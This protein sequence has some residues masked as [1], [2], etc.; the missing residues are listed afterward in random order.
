MTELYCLLSAI[1]IIAFIFSMS[2]LK[3]SIGV[4]A[5]ISFILAFLIGRCIMGASL[6]VLF[7]GCLEGLWNTFIIMV[8]VF[9]ALLLYELLEKSK[10]LSTL[11][12]W[13]GSH[14]ED[15]VDQILMIGWVFTSFLQGVTG[16]GVPV[17]VAA[18]I[19]TGLG[20]EP[21]KAVIICILGHAWGGTFGTLGIAW[22][23]M[24]LQLP[25]G[26]DVYMGQTILYTCILLGIYNFICGLLICAL[27]KG[28][29]IKAR[30]LMA[31]ALISSVQSMGQLLFALF[32]NESLACFLASA[33]SM[34]VLYVWDRGL[35]RGRTPVSGKSGSGRNGRSDSNAGS[36]PVVDMG[37][38]FFI[39]SAIVFLL[40]M[41]TKLSAALEGCRVGMPV[42]DP[43]GGWTVYGAVSVFTHSGTILLT[44]VAVSFWFYR[45]KKYLCRED[46]GKML[47]NAGRKTVNAV[48]PVLFLVMMSR[49]MSGSGQIGFLASGIGELFGGWVGFASPFIGILGSFIS[50]SN[51]ASNI[52]FT[53]LQL[54]LSQMQGLNAAAILAAQTAG[55]SVGNLVAAGN[56]VLGL[57]I[58]GKGGEELKVMRFMAPVCIA[59]GAVCG[60]ITLLVCQT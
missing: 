35:C 20:V 47:R 16:F 60:F 53:E 36:V 43:G 21:R 26:H 40:V 33:A 19:L 11:S 24:L 5:L 52:L 58:V 55:G 2:F 51:M 13:V 38:P 57:S 41:P 42:P 12:Q 34:A 10:M 27:Y 30:E 37:F 3:K 29:K 49:I 23:S 4:A 28:K 56:I 17:A 14:I 32:F 22:N 48:W 9:S 18:P 45:R 6:S 50:S 25:D 46:T 54:R 15:K 39:L 1:P 8:V 31:V 59:I 44:A 7:S